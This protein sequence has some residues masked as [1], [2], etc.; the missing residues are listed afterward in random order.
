LGGKK[1][2]P[3]LKDENEDEWQVSQLFIWTYTN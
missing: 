3:K 2:A 1:A